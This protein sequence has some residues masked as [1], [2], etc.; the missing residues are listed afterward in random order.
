[1]D[2]HESSIRYSILN[3]IFNASICCELSS[4]VEYANVLTLSACKTNEL[5]QNKAS[6]IW[7][8]QLFRKEANGN[9]LPVGP[10]TVLCSCPSFFDAL[11]ATSRLYS[12]NRTSCV[13]S[14]ST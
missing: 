1:M 2:N 11:T 4:I 9:D 8:A 10:E 3:D 6:A 5:F 12:W 13:T 14:D 7:L